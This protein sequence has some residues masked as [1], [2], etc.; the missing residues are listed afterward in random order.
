MPRRLARLPRGHRQPR[1]PRLKLRAERHLA[2][3][4]ALA[5]DDPQRPEVAAAHQVP[6]ERFGV[7]VR[8]GEHRDHVPGEGRAARAAVVPQQQPLV[9]GHLPG[10]AYQAHRVRPEQQV[11]PAR[12][13]A[14]HPLQRVRV[15]AVV[16][17]QQLG[18][19]RERAP[20]GEPA[21]GLLTEPGEP[22]GQRERRPDTQHAVLLPATGRLRPAHLGFQYFSSARSRSVTTGFQVGGSE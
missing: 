5:L 10:P 13:V 18:A 19:V 22:A 14:Q 20:G 16:L 6:D 4:A 1:H 2:G 17:D 21:R 9:H 8:G 11:A 7:P 12:Q 15:A 3:E